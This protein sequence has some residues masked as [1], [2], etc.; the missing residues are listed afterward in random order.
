M[1]HTGIIVVA[2]VLLFTF[3]SE[4]ISYHEHVD[5]LSFGEEESKKEEKQESVH[6]E[7]LIHP[8]TGEPID[9]SSGI[10]RDPKT[11]EIVDEFE[12][13][14]RFSES[15]NGCV[16]CHYNKE[17]TEQ[18]V[19]EWDKSIHSKKQVNCTKCH[20]GNENSRNVK[21]AK[22]EGTK[23]KLIGKS[24]L[25]VKDEELSKKAFEYCGQ[26]HGTI[27]RD[28]TAGIHGKRT[29]F[30]NGKKE[31]WVCI[32]CHSAHDTKFKSLKPK[33]PPVRPYDIN[34]DSYLKQTLN[35]D[36]TDNRQPGK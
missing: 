34:L 14:I 31:Y 1:K 35:K 19:L 29:G 3:Q 2:A 32:K 9:P 26:C 17:E 16:N 28:W 6:D 8:I 12:L 5:Y 15:R 4:T 13:I 18:L 23:Y 20:G 10:F 30:W 36:S 27:F 22:G 25:D 24:L 11:G 33:P 7:I 21:Q